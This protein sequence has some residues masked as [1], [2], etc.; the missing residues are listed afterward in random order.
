[1]KKLLLLF[2]FISLVSK[3]QTPYYKL[4]GNNTDWYVFNDY[5]PLSP[6]HKALSPS[7]FAV[8]YGKYSAH[9]DTLVMGNM[10]KKF[11]HVYT[12]P[13]SPSN[14]HLGYIR[15]DSATRKVYFLDKTSS[16]EDLLYD[17]SVNTGDSVFLNFP[18]A[19]GNFPLGY[20]KV[21]STGTVT[22]N[23]GP[24]K[25]FK[26]TK[27]GTSSYDTLEIIESVGCKIHPVY[28]YSSFY[29]MGQF[30]SWGPSP[31]CTYKY[32]IGLACKY[33]DSTKYFQSCTYT[34]AQTMGCIFKYDSCNYYNTC[35]GISEQSIVRDFRIA[36][37]P[38]SFE[39]EVLISLNNES[40]VNI[41][42][43]DLSGRRIKVFSS[44]ELPAGEH[45][46]K[47]D[48]T[49]IESGYYFI[50]AASREF[51]LNTP[52]IISR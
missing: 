6:G 8:T 48:V 40:S 2:S 32:D 20:Y 49:G 1:M 22:I 3:S 41:S 34:L 19:G 23:T 5:I 46:I 50:R 14:Q 38:A 36:P 43:F 44:S 28:M 33:T 17:F 39:T 35:S 24:R 10:Y 13:S 9:T 27:S 25:L 26:L 11:Y 12:Y 4:L 52:F 18:T 47:L 30:G 45:A 21:R 15:E 37:N 7:A 31:S 29:G 51:E 42:L 16:T